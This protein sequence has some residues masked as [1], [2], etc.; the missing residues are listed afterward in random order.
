LF[1]P[2]SSPGQFLFLG[3]DVTQAMLLVQDAALLSVI[4]S[5]WSLTGGLGAWQR[6][7]FIF[8]LFLATVLGM[9]TLAVH[10]FYS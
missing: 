2:A 9:G 8:V 5:L 10:S 3:I 6:A 4:F 7:I 1:F